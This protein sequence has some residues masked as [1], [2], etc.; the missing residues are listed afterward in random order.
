MPT[1]HIRY[2]NP[3]PAVKQLLFG[4]SRTGAARWT[5]F[6]SCTWIAYAGDAHAPW[7]ACY[8]DRSACSAA[9][10]GPKAL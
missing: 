9:A 1:I 6:R 4:R 8:P 7:G 2:D 3:K 5:V 10:G